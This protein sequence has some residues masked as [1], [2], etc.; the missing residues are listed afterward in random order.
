MPI[1]TASRIN[2]L[3][4]KI[5]SE[6]L[7]RNGSGTVA[8]YGSATYDYTVLPVKGNVMLK[9]HANKNL[10]PMQAVNSTGLPTEMVIVKDSDI[11]V[12]ETRVAALALTTRD[13]RGTSDCAS[14]CTGMCVT[15]CTTSCWNVCT[16]CT[17]VCTGCTGCTGCS[18]CSGCGET[19]SSSC[20]ECK[21]V[22]GGICQ[23]T[24]SIGC[25]S[26]CGTTAQQT[27]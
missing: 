27:A 18:G 8:A 2:T 11:T 4:A 15:A 25:Y 10:T 14:G 7:R 1:I 24:C 26:G 16:S 9:E 21:G 13:N 22:C 19:C 20:Y 6:M 3:K 17:N 12:L 5:K 23:G